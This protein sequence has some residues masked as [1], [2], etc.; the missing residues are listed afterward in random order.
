[1]SSILFKTFLLSKENWIEL[2]A[3]SCIINKTGSEIAATTSF[4]S[5]KYYALK[6][7]PILL[8]KV[9]EGNITQS[10]KKVLCEFYFHSLTCIKTDSIC[11][12][13]SNLET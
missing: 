4:L 9:Y 7:L 11:F 13:R 8:T 3:L 10:S 2:I 6:T 12:D 5:V 1:M